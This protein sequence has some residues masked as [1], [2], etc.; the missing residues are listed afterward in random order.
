MIFE[1]TP[2]AYSSVN[3]SVIYVVYDANAADTVTYP[4]Y[5]Y[6]YEVWIN[7]AIKFTGKVFPQPDSNRGIFDVGNIVREYVNASLKAELGEGEFSVSVVLKLREE[8][9]GSVGPVVLTD[10]T[11]VFFN[12][13]NGRYNDF[14]LLASYANKPATNRPLKVQMPVNTSTYYLPYF[15]TTTTPFDVVINGVTT[16]I[17]PTATNT[18]HNINIAINATTN[19]T[20]VIAGVT[21]NVEIVCKGLFKNYIIHF[22]NKFGGYES[23]LFNKANKRTFDIGRKTFQQ[24]PYRVSNAGV[25]SVKSGSIMHPQKTTFASRFTEKLKVQT[26]WLTDA[27]HDWLF[28]LVTSPDVYLDDAGTLYPIVITDTNYDVKQYNIDKLTTL[29]VNIEFGTSYKTQYK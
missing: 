17:T 15:A 23:M 22:L 12:H 29:S 7:G 3:D 8:Y 1:S 14:T 19:Y 10:S 5:K 27:E 21:Y 28:Q 9:D 18:M 16:T 25:V 20:V 2:P 24:L 11:R 13:Y 6:V 26:D 4:N